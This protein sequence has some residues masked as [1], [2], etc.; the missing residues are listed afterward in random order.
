MTAA[1][2]VEVLPGGAS[3]ARF[4]EIFMRDH[5]AIELVTLNLARRAQRSNRDTPIGAM[6]AGIVSE[7][8]RE[9]R[10]LRDV[11]QRASIRPAWLKMAGAWVAEK[12]GRLKLNGRL[13][14]RSPLS[15]VVELQGLL[16]LTAQRRA[17]WRILERLGRVDSRFAGLDFAARLRALDDQRELLERSVLQAADDAL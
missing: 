7:L 15:P 3:R 11:A 8:E 17:M 6:L 1:E 2:A 13:V 5:L 16:M 14:G 10:V 12:A 4:R 9:E